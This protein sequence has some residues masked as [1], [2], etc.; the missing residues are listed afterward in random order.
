VLSLIVADVLESLVVSHNGNVVI[1]MVHPKCK[2]PRAIKSASLV[3]VLG[4][5]FAS[6]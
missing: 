5:Q 3:V 6:Y 4:S 2:L 1:D